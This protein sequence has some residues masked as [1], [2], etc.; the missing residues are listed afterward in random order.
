MSSVNTVGSEGSFYVVVMKNIV[1]LHN[2]MILSCYCDI[3]LDI[4]LNLIS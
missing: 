3:I 1:E 2:I 4:V